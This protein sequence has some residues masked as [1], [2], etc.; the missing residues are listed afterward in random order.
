MMPLLS[1]LVPRGNG[2]RQSLEPAPPMLEAVLGVV[3]MIARNEKLEPVLA[4][5]AAM[6]EERARGLRCAVMLLRNGRLYHAAGGGLPPGFVSAVNGLPVGGDAARQSAPFWDP[7][8]RLADIAADPRWEEFRAA[9]LAAGL[10]SCWSFPLL[11]PTGE[12]L[13]VLAAYAGPGREF[14][15]AERDLLSAAGRLAAVS[16][17]QR[18]LMDDLAHQAGHDPLTRLANRYLFDDRLQQALYA[19]ERTRQPVALV[20]L[21]LDRFGAV[22]DLLGH[23][24]GDALLEHV[25]RRLE[26]CVR[27]SDTLARTGGDEFCLVLPA[28]GSAAD[29]R[30]VASKLRDALSDPFHVH[31]HE[32]FV[33]ASIGVSV[34][35]DDAGDTAALE[36]NATDAM[37]RAKALGRNNVQAFT[38]EMNR[39]N[40]E[41]LEMENNLRKALDRAEIYLAYQPQ[42]DL[43]TGAL[44]GFEALLRWENPTLGK[45][46]PAAFV[47]L[48]EETGLIGGLGAWVLD[49]ACRQR[50]AWGEALG[51]LRVAVNVSA[52]QFARPDFISTV[53]ATLQAAGL[54]PE[55]LELELTE[56][57][58][59]Q[60]IEQAAAKMARL[61]DMGI[62]I[63]MDDFGT[64]YSSLSYIQRLPFESVKIDQSFVREIRLASDRPPLVGSIIGMAHALH[65]RV[66]AEG[67]ETEAQLQ[68][69][70]EMDC[71]IG[72]GYFLGRPAPP[73]TAAFTPAA[74]FAG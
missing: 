40:M 22:N 66:I 69:L 42:F 32:L 72:Q 57:V 12:V 70:I 50:A 43:R 38:A 46:S 21:D 29:A 1:V 41:R 44:A 51:A 19:A 15:S 53:A 71:D 47:P 63:S 39:A 4:G 11:S 56:S 30:A 74:G 18:N 58:I 49:R 48:A 23:R 10:A 33:T 45:V 52:L 8:P 34:Y 64:G 6:V 73:D 60:D 26:S 37:F 54:S 27:K 67:I 65:K 36:R 13:G 25:A 3:E 20:A 61:R 14:A 59:M 17:E 16:I 5:V 28:L 9:A 68:A 31:G 55:R 35:P 24:V 7:A 62:S 2:R